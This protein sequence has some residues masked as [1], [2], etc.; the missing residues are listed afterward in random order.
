MEVELKN[1]LRI[2]EDFWRQKAGMKWFSEGDMI[3]K[4]F[5]SYVKGRRKKLHLSAIET[6]Q[7]DIVNTNEQIGDAAVKFYAEQFREEDNDRNFEILE[8]NTRSISEAEM[9]R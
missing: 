4:F 9:R 3:T 7:G 2:E 5:H 6:D 8:H 1:Y